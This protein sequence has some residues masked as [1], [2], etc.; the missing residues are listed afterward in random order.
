M[1]DSLSVPRHGNCKE[2]QS[3]L[4]VASNCNLPTS[5]ST[6]LTPLL[7]GH[8]GRSHHGCCHI[9]SNN[10]TTR[11]GYSTHFWPVLFTVGYIPQH[12]RMC[13]HGGADIEMI[14][15]HPTYTLL[16]ASTSVA[17]GNMLHYN[18]LFLP[19]ITRAEKIGTDIF[20]VHPWLLFNGRRCYDRPGI[21]GALDISSLFVDAKCG[22][23]DYVDYHPSFAILTK[24]C[25]PWEPSRLVLGNY[26]N[27]EQISAREHESTRAHNAHPPRKYS[28]NIIFR[29]NFLR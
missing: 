20:L 13:T 11:S 19:E 25:Q 7:I 27:L 2:T 4:Q 24:P 16:H 12:I 21:S 1:V 9:L 14:S 18:L 5:V 28:E 3:V 23:S 22:H 15:C 29:G 6:V 8:D 26:S 10:H 17:A